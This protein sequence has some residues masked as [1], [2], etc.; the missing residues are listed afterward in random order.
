ME[1][2]D[3]G[4][5]TRKMSSAVANTAK[6]FL[7]LLCYQFMLLHIPALRLSAKLLSLN[8]VFV[9]CNTGD[10]LFPKKL[11]NLNMLVLVPAQELSC[12]IILSICEKTP[13]KTRQVSYDLN[14]FKNTESFLESAFVPFLGVAHRSANPH[15]INY[16][17]S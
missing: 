14:F 17:M 12:G 9:I 6:H 13:P 15:S 11:F 16:M 10:Y 5:E 4:G 2:Q 1:R 8:N 3:R 7:C